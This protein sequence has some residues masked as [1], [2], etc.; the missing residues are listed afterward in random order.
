VLVGLSAAL[1]ATGHPA[2]RPFASACA[3]VATGRTTDVA[4][5][6]HRHAARGEFCERL[7]RLMGAI[8]AG[9]PARLPA[10]IAT[11]LDWGAT[12]GADG[13]LGVLLGLRAAVLRGAA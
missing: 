7:H 2:A 6:L 1:F 9:E 8:L 11:A 3:M 12:S 10:A 13:L 4:E 5:R